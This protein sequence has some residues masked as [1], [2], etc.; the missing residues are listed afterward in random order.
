M[1][2]L[3]MIRWQAGERDT[4]WPPTGSANRTPTWDLTETTSSSRSRGEE[5]PPTW[6][7]EH[8]LV[9]NEGLRERKEEEGD[10]LQHYY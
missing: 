7:R 3:H 10:L 1:L 5:C 9:R 8:L 2:L 4:W 6:C